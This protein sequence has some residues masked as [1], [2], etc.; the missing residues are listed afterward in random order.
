VYG[1]AYIFYEISDW[2]NSYFWWLYDIY[3]KPNYKELVINHFEEIVFKIVKLNYE[4]SGC[5]VR[6][7][8]NE[9]SE[10]FYEKTILEKSNYIIYEKE[11]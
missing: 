10:N 7:I 11:L 3:A 8:T 5:G 2:R 9:N 6:A 1:F 4:L